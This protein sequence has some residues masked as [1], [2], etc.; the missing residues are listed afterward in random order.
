MIFTFEGLIHYCKNKER[1]LFYDIE[2]DKK[3]RFCGE[4]LTQYQTTVFEISPQQVSKN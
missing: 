4:D 1:K 3:C 2:L